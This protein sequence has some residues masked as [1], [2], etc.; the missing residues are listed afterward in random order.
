[1]SFRKPFLLIALISLLTSAFL[2][3]CGVSAAAVETPTAAPEPTFTPIP[4]LTPVPDQ[5]PPAADTYTLSAALDLSAHTVQVQETIRYTNRQTEALP[6][7]MLAA[8]ANAYTGAFQLSQLTWQDGQAV[9]N[10][11]LAR[12]QLKIPLKAP[13]APGGTIEIHAAY[14]ITL[15]HLVSPGTDVRPTPFG[16]TEN[17]TN[18]VDWILLVAPYQ[19]GKGWLIHEP[20]IFG[21][22]QVYSTADYTADLTVSPAV[23]GLVVAASAPETRNGDVRHYELANARNFALS[24]SSE[25][26]VNTRQVG[27]VTVLGY[28]LPLY[29]NAAKQALDDT[30]RAL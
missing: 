6:E 28:N 21:E 8:E 3:S 9:E 2:S 16:Y 20:S 4:T 14:Q 25:Y 29:P 27:D 30:A 26:Q 17:Q 15:P 11:A 10:I 22:H 18:L 23:E 24:V 13:L 19:T 12:N 7:L 1:M 5:E